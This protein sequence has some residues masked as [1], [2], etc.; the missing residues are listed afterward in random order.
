MVF[1]LVCFGKKS[2]R[3]LLGFAH[4]T[5]AR[6]QRSLV[7]S[8]VAVFSVGSLPLMPCTIMSYAVLAFCVS[9]TFSDFS[10]GWD[11]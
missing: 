10:S 5:R 11:S 9:R 1:W 4:Q 2:S 8:I 3:D 7:V 6:V